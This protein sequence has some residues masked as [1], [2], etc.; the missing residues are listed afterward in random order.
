MQTVHAPSIKFHQFKALVSSAACDQ[1]KASYQSGYHIGNSIHHVYLHNPNQLNI[2]NEEKKERNHSAVTNIAQALSTYVERNRAY[3][4][5]YHK[6]GTV[7]AALF[8]NGLTLNSVEDF[9]RYGVFFM[10]IS[11]LI[12]YSTDPK[13]GHLDSVH[14]LGVYSFMLEELDALA[15]GLPATQNVRPV[16]DPKYCQHVY[17]IGI[18]I[19][20]DTPRKHTGYEA[21]GNME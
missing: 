15:Q 16:I 11:K 21:E 3:G 18:C 1:C 4:N 12:R 19:I 5:S 20:C 17:E 14:D 9:N 8:P 13:K 7:M 6:F 10:Q 2:A